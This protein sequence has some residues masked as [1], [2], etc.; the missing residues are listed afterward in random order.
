MD[1]FGEEYWKFRYFQKSLSLVLYSEKCESKL[2]TARI[3]SAC[4]HYKNNCRP[5]LIWFCVTLDIDAI[6]HH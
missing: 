5:L 1:M 6:T 4:K 2:L 3:H